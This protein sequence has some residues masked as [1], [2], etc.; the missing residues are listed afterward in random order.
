[1]GC[2]V[3]AG[4]SAGLI[5]QGSWLDRLAKRTD[6]SLST[7]NPE[8]NMSIKLSRPISKCGKSESLQLAALSL[9]PLNLH[10]PRGPSFRMNPAAP[11]QFFDLGLQTLLWSLSPQP[12][13]DAIVTYILV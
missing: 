10:R 9:E 2:G 13:E 11:A 6:V 1:M 3:S 8:S 4:F 5:E 12:Y 7:S